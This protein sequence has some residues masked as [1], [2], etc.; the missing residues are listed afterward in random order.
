MWRRGSIQDLFIHGT[1][2][3]TVTDDSLPCL[4]IKSAVLLDRALW[5]S[6][7][8]NGA[9]RGELDCVFGPS[10]RIPQNVDQV[11]RTGRFGRQL[12]TH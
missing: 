5:V 10:Y 11:M 12:K 6:R 4:K 1:S 9:L 3:T 8:V 7:M 2:S